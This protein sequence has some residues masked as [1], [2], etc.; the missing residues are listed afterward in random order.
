MGLDWVYRGSWKAEHTAVIAT[1][2]PLYQRW[3][4]FDLHSGRSAAAFI[5]FVRT[6]AGGVLL[7]DALVWLAAASRRH[8]RFWTE[9][10]LPDAAARLLAEALTDEA[11]LRRNPPS[12]ESLKD[13]LGQLCNLQNMIALQIRES[14]AAS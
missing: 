8:P 4:D 12:F 7:K 6:P 13:L 1:L 11:G 3:A 2:K 14:L 10:G 9:S 5:A